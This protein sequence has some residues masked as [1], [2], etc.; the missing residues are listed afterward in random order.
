MK[1]VHTLGKQSYDKIRAGT[2]PEPKQ[3]NK[4][5]QKEAFTNKCKKQRLALRQEQS[6]DTDVCEC[7]IL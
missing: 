3:T 1:Q 7:F 2:G 5:Q 6:H 4:Q